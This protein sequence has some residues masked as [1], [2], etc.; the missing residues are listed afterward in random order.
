MVDKFT[1]ASQILNDAAK[2]SDSCVVFYSG[3]KDSLVVMD[4]ATKAFK[5]V[6]PVFM[7]FVPGLSIIEKQLEFARTRWGIDVLQIPHWKLFWC[8]KNG[9]YCLPSIKNQEKIPILKIKDIYNYVL[10]K[11]GIS[12][13]ATGAKMADSVWRRQ[14]F[15]ATE[16]YPFLLTP[17]KNWNKFDVLY[18]LNKNNIPLPDNEGGNATGIDL[19]TPVILWLYDKHREDYNR[20][21]HIFPFIGTVIKRRE[22]YGTGSKKS[23]SK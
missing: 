2:S 7:Y 22:L 14:N 11:T 19:T 13:I 23:R 17:L 8:I 4:L 12:Y 20:M 18:Y 15:K 21:S 6:V 9:F 1:E 3:G 5:K 10:K 16:N